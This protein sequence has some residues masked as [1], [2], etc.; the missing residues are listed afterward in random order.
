MLL[1][2]LL[3]LFLVIFYCCCYFL[4]LLLFLF[5]LLFFV[6]VVFLFVIVVVV[7]SMFTL[8][9]CHMSHALYATVNQKSTTCHTYIQRLSTPIN[10][11]IFVAFNSA[12]WFLVSLLFLLLPSY[13]I[14]NAAFVVFATLSWGLLIA[15]AC[16]YLVPTCILHISIFSMSCWQTDR[17]TDW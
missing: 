16:R 12:L 3:C 9:P 11:W 1:F 6:F 5:L 13:S 10:V 4:L 17:Q 8:A 14:H 15:A 2:L 7:L